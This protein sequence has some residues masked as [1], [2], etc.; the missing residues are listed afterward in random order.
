MEITDI[1]AYSIFFVTQIVSF[2]ALFMRI[3]FTVESHS[4]S[5]EHIISEN[6]A[7]KKEVTEI[8]LN[9]VQQHS[10]KKF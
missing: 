8:K 10:K 9:C 4:K 7:L 2:V 5:I 1:I 3:K 6:I